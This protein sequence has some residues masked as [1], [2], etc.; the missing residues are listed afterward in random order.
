MPGMKIGDLARRTGTNTPTIRYY[1]EIGLI[2]RA[3]RQDGG[4]RRYGDEDVK[5]LTLIRRCREFGFPIEQ[6]RSLVTLAEEPGRSCLE[7]RDLSR[8]HLAA[9]RTK[10]RE[11]KA[12]ERSLVRF[13]E[14]CETACAGG[15]GPDCTILEDLA[16]P[17]GRAK[18][19]AG[20]GRGT[21]RRRARG[22]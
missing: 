6:I 16:K 19:A 14:S 3:D 21:G 2:P 20:M 15:P 8:E 1:E 5:R 4:Q 10:L 18:V 13:V 11:L 9:V 17:S 12:L 7:A 22:S